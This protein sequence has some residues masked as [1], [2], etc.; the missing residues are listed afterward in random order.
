MLDKYTLIISMHADPA[1]P[2]GYEEWGGTHT[3]MKELLDEFTRNHQYCILVTRLSM[4]YLPIKEKYSEFCSI[5]RLQN[6]ETEPMSKLKLRDFH[7]ENVIAIKKIV[8]ELKQKPSALHSVYWNSGRIAMELSKIFEIPFVHSVISNSKGRV[9][10]GAKEHISDRAIYEQQIF[11]AAKEILCVSEDE[12]NDLIKLYNIPEHKLTVAGQYIDESFLFPSHDLN[13]FPLLN[14]KNLKQETTDI[15][16]TYNKVFHKTFETDTFWIQKSFVYFGRIDKSKGIHIIIQAWYI[17]YKKYKHMCPPLWI[18]GG[19][20]SEIIE[21]RKELKQCVAEL[22]NLE[23][24]YQIVWWGYVDFKGISTIL[25]KANS[26]IMH[27]LY[28]PGGRVA[29]EAMCEQ[30][31]VIATPRGFAQDIIIDWKNGFLVN[32]SDK[33]LL[34]HRMEHFIRQPLLSNVLGRQARKDALE[35]VKKWNF[36][37]RHFT[38]YGVNQIVKEMKYDKSNVILSNN[39]I[40]IY[41]FLS[42][43]LSNNYILKNL[44]DK[45]YTLCH[46]DSSFKPQENEPF[47]ARILTDKENVMVKQHQT[48]M[49]TDL[50]FNPL[51]NTEYAISGHTYYSIEKA[52]YQRNENEIAISFDD[53]HLLVYV[54]ELSIPNRNSFDFIDNC[55][56]YIESTLK[57]FPFSDQLKPL[58][59]LQ[60]NGN[61][62]DDLNTY[63]T[64]LNH[65]FSDFIFERNCFFSP[66]LCWKI[67]PYIIKYNSDSITNQTM[68]MLQNAIDFFSKKSYPLSKKDLYIINPL[69]KLN[70]IF[71]YGRNMVHINH[72]HTSIGPCEA[73]FAS[74]LYDYCYNIPTE[75]LSIILSKLLNNTSLQQFNLTMLLS[76]MAYHSF[77]NLIKDMVQSIEKKRTKNYDLLENILNVAYE[78]TFAGT[79]S[80]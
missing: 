62:I 38:A 11:D 49:A 53:E 73:T 48:R 20:L 47:I 64:K 24:S 14:C 5:Y 60:N 33:T 3:Y 21:M 26:V 6:G 78:Y 80:R 37:N 29:V 40:D 41:P 22:D 61:S 71:M 32:Y 76:L 36:T 56:K 8:D 54:H 35:I 19:S 16:Y 55:L 1:M 52:F 25:L 17:L 39:Q 15:G 72:E 70:D 59:K 69:M 18:I 31:P 9:L 77:Y 30:V 74:L 79:T 45:S 66:N 63:F 23:R 4:R 44:E 7:N 43:P 13:D 28:E 51:L 50:L 67:A 65:I 68:M 42:I 12:K 58:E 34:A 57:R 2:P 10:R 75:H 46:I 27:S